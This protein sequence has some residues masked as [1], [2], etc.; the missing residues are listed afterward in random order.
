MDPLHREERQV[1]E[2]CKRPAMT[3]IITYVGARILQLSTH[4]K[5]VTDD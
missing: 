2:L 3:A 1:D 4:Q 5:A